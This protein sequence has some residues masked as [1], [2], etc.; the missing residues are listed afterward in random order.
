M[1][2]AV[3]DLMS[4][5]ITTMLEGKKVSFF[6]QDIKEKHTNVQSTPIG[7]Q[8]ISGKMQRRNIEQASA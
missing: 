5:L 3:E 2:R 7:C 8:V 4:P 6:G 1:R